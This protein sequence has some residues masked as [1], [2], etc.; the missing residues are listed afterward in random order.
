MAFV[1]A[2][3]ADIILC[4]EMASLSLEELD[5]FYHQ[6]DLERDSPPISDSLAELP[7][8]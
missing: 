1:E 8:V 4:E 6:Q 7:F 2:F 3:R 5:E